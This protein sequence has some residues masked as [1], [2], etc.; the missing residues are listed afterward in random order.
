MESELVSPKPMKV[1][2]TSGRLMGCKSMKGKKICGKD[3][4]L[5]YSFIFFLHPMGLST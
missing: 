3:N 4:A 1:S 2:L 5:N